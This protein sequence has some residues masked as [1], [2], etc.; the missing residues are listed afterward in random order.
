MI[1]GSGAQGP[2]RDRV[3]VPFTQNRASVTMPVWYTK[4]QCESFSLLAHLL[5]GR[6]D[7]FDQPPHQRSEACIAAVQQLLQQMPLLAVLCPSAQRCIAEHA[8]L[9]VLSDLLELPS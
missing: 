5:P 4:C 8:K 9:V 2:C 7:V 6:Q 3:H 1:A